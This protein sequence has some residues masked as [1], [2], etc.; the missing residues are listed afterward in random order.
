MSSA[1]AAQF[2]D[3]EFLVAGVEQDCVHMRGY[4]HSFV[5]GLG[6]GH[7]HDL[8]D[9]N[10][11]Q[12]VLQVAMRAD[13]EMVADLDRIGPAEALLLDDVGHALPRRQQERPDR[14]WNRRGNL[15][16]LFVADDAGAAR[17]M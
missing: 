12:G 1:G 13:G 14:G 15:C 11:G 3:G 10:S 6:T 16:N 4:P 2:L 9:R 8:N 5:D 7:V 17:H